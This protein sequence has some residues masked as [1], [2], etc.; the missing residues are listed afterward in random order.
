MSEK[1]DVLDLIINVLKEHEKNLS[2]YISR[3]EESIKR[4]ERRVEE[5]EGEKALKEA[6]IKVEIKEW[7]EFKKQA[8]KPESVY[9]EVND[10]F[11]QV[12]AL[13]EAKINLY[14]ERLPRL[15]VEVEREGGKYVL[16]RLLMSDAEDLPL[17]LNSEL[18]CGFKAPLRSSIVEESENKLRVE[19]SLG[20]EISKIKSWISNELSFPVKKLV[21]GKVILP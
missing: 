18:K 2:K 10:R 21:K 4:L 8:I 7:S 20:I 6:K 16:K 9:F 11:F 5:K 13:K 12:E 14:R 3:L 15:I 1:M 17:I 19:V